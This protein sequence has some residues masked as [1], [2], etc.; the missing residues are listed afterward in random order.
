MT[1]EDC[2]FNG[3]PDECC[4][5]CEGDPVLGACCVGQICVPTT[6]EGCAEA[7]GLWSVVGR[8]CADFQCLPPEDCLG[9]VNQDGTVDFDDLVR[10]IANW[11]V[12]P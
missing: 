5:L 10:L 2:N 7:G 1:S 3:V 8:E 6:I 11:G 4:E 9:D 12:C